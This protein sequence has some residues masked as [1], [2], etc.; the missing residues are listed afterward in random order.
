MKESPSSVVN[1]FDGRASSWRSGSTGCSRVV[2]AI[3]S[4]P[5]FWWSLVKND[6][7][8]HWRSCKLF[9]PVKNFT[10]CWRFWVPIR[11]VHTVGCLVNFFSSYVV[12][13]LEVLLQPLPNTSKKKLSVHTSHDA[14]YN[15]EYKCRKI[16]ESGH[17]NRL[18]GWDLLCAHPICD[19]DLLKA[20]PFSLTDYEVLFKASASG[21]SPEA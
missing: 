6:A 17:S 4:S 8:F 5:L 13:H 16:P 9:K 21:I 7:F 11:L 1:I 18:H 2:S 12:F 3:R 19:L 10:A 20:N 15:Y 14:Q